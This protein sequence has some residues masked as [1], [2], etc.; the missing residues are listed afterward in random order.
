MQGGKR[1]QEGEEGKN[2][3]KAGWPEVRLQHALRRTARALL[4]RRRRSSRRA[5]RRTLA[6]R[7]GAAFYCEL[8]ALCGAFNVACRR[9]ALA[10][11][12]L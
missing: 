3:A 4:L 6:W 1:E 11:L 2:K 8:I 9:A 5:V 12:P 7:V 10:S